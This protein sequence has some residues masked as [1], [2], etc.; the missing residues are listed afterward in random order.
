MMRRSLSG[1][2]GLARSRDVMAKYRRPPPLSN[3]FETTSTVP[4]AASFQDVP[5][6]STTPDHVRKAVPIPAMIPTPSTEPQQPVKEM[7]K[8][9]I[10]QG[11]VIPPKPVPPKDDGTSPLLF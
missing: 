5:P 9:M 11:V 4:A 3:T 8:E 10:V 6:P 1:T 7:D 2:A